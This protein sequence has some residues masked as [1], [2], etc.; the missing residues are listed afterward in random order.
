MDS[1][2]ALNFPKLAM[3]TICL[4]EVN[5]ALAA[6]LGLV[7]GPKRFLGSTHIGKH[8]LFSKFFSILSPSYL[9]GLVGGSIRQDYNAPS[10][11]SSSP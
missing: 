11:T 5:Q 10:S 6:V 4:K 3:G 9:S 1:F 2:R 8:I 7:E